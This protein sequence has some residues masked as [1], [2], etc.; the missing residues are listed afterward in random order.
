MLNLFYHIVYVLLCIYVLYKS[1][2]YGIYEAKYENNKFGG[3]LV[4]FVTLFDVIFSNIIVW[5]N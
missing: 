2:S 1:I 3:S 5:Q 4:I